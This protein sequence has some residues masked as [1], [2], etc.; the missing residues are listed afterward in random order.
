MSA[1]SQTLSNLVV[2]AEELTARPLADPQRTGDCLHW[3]AAEVRAADT[4]PVEGLRLTSAALVMVTAIFE[5][6]HAPAD[7]APMWLMLIGATLPLLRQAA[8]DAFTEERECR[9]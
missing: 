7:R 9:Q 5:Y 4:R 6:R 3:L 2:L 1:L 8:F